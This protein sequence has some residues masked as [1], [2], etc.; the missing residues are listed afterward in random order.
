LRINHYN[1]DYWALKEARENKL[2]GAE[3][4]KEDDSMG[5]M[6]GGLIDQICKKGCSENFALKCPKGK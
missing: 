2:S 3:K 5:Q 4:F 1:F 6:Y